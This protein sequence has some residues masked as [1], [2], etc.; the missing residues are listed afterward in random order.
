MTQRSI[1]AAKEGAK[2]VPTEAGIAAAVVHAWFPPRRWAVCPNVSWGLPL[3]GEAD[4][5]AV[6]S[7]G[8]LHEIEI[9]CSRGDLR[10]DEKKRRWLWSA[11][12]RTDYYWLAVPAALR[13]DG[14]RRAEALH[15]GL[16][17]ASAPPDGDRLPVVERLRCA[18]RLPSKM[19]VS[20]GDL[21]NRVWRLASLRYWDAVFRG[22]IPR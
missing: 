16:F 5:I 17:V 3:L 11:D 15:A 20:P 9:K 21:R 1:T 14:M 10:A 22:A 6:S 19:S 4:V 7:S 13:D 18:H 8:K 2:W 12:A